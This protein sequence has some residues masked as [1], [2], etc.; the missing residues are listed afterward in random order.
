MA[1]I[2][3][4]ECSSSPA[5]E[6][7]LF[8][9]RACTLRIEIACA[10]Q[11]EALQTIEQIHALPKVLEALEVLRALQDFNNSQRDDYE[12]IAHQV[13]EVLAE[14]DALTPTGTSN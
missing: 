12:V 7:L 13:D 6:G 3:A 11:A 14:I 9:N 10:D 5:I 8:Y 4:I 2:S 1:Y